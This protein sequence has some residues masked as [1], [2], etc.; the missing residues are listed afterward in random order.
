MRELFI[1]KTASG[2]YAY[3]AAGYDWQFGTHDYSTTIAQ[4]I[5][6][7]GQYDTI[8]NIVY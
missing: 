6:R 5:E 3:K 4:A 7:F 8:T 1:R 2:Q